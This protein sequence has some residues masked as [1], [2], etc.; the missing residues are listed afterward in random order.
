MRSFWYFIIYSFF[1]FLLEVAFARLI[2]SE[3]RDR[4]CFLLLPL[5][6]V[7]GLGAMAILA[8][9]APV[10]AS[11]PLLGLFGGL[12]ATGVEYLMA[13]VYEKGMGVAFWDY[14]Q[15]RGNWQGRVCPL[16]SVFWGLLSLL[17]IYRVHPAVEALLPAMPL[18]LTLSALALVLADGL[19]TV[20]LL[21]RTGSAQSLRWYAGR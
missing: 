7:Y 12:A 1:G 3:K 20:V 14:S 19:C 13:L 17:L 4:K 9:P 10:R 15:L 11:P 5:C 8:L 16:F 2:R 21:R 18:P 6:P